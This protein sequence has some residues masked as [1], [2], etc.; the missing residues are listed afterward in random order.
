MLVEFNERKFEVLTYIL[1][2]GP[3]TPS[4]LA[5]A[6]HLEIHNARMRLLNYFRQGLLAR[7]RGKMG[8]SFSLTEKGRRRLDFLSGEKS[9]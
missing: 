1:G 9:E 7:H 8:A 4:E 6:L 2:Y 5:F 3:V